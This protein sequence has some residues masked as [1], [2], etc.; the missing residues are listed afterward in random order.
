MMTLTYPEEYPTDGKVVKRHLNAMLG[1]L[2]Y[3]YPGLGYLWYLEFQ[4]RGAPHVH[5]LLTFGLPGCRDKRIAK[6][7]KVAKAWYRIVDSGDVKHLLACLNWDNARKKNGLAHYVAWYAGKAQ[8]KQVPEDYQNVG[9]FWGKSRNI[10]CTPVDQW[11]TD[12]ATLRAC[13]HSWDYLPPPGKPLYRVLYN[14]SDH[15]DQAWKVW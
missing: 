14:A 3:N 1:W 2:R 4:E 7:K 6:R 12:E 10:T 13:L 5:I 9:R 11:V 15:V 8:Q